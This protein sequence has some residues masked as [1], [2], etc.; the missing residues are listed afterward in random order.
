MKNYS[1][2]SIPKKGGNSFRKIYKPTI[3]FKKY[4]QSLLP[5]LEQIYLKHKIYTFDHAFFTGHNSVTN[6]KEHLKYR[7]VLS[8]DISNFFESITTNHLQEYLPPYLLSIVLVDEKLPQGFPTSPYLSN[9][10]MIKFDAKIYDILK[11]MDELITYTRYADDLTVSFNNPKLK[12]QIIGITAHLLKLYN[13]KLNKSKI[14]FQDKENGRV[15]ITGV[16]ITYD[17]IHPTRETLKKLRAA[18][19]QNNEMSFNGLA[20]WSLCKPPKTSP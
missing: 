1:L 10:A 12:N 18:R 17:S 2:I 9:I 11:K 3:D 6:A 15:I 16:A 4:L 8:L 7:Y 20:E 5:E 19:F 13:F 14:K